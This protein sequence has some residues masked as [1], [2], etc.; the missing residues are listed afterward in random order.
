[1]KEQLHTDTANTTFNIS[2]FV[3]QERENLILCRSSFINFTS[4][5]F[6]SFSW[7]NAF[8]T[9][10]FAIIHIY[11]KLFI[12]TFVNI[13][14]KE[15]FRIIQYLLCQIIYALD[16]M[17]IRTQRAIVWLCK[18]RKSRMIFIYL[19]RNTNTIAFKECASISFIST[20]RNKWLI[21][22]HHINSFFLKRLFQIRQKK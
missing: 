15:Q 16:I 13:L 6:N 4:S 21:T 5:N 1:M 10:I 11:S 12:D 3:F 8:Y 17:K 22:Y 19:C 20:K 9:M 18:H 2:K 14:H 7:Y